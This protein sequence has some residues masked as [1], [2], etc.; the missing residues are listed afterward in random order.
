MNNN[1]FDLS[2]LAASLPDFEA[3]KLPSFELPKL[4]FPDNSYFEESLEAIHQANA[5]KHRRE[6]EN[7]ESLKAIV[8]YNEDISRYNKELVSLN[9]KILNKINSLDDT[10]TFLNVA[11]S[12]KANKDNENSEKQLTLL[13]ELITIIENKD[14]SKLEAFM[15]NVGAPVGVGL[16]IEALKIKFGLG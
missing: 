12:E 7:N 13:V 8:D 4:E 6:I 9:E 14:S 10:L 5:E 11:L 16:L 15:N 1:S 2:K 3:P